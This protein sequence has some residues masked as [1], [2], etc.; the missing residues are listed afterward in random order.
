VERL[1]VKP[2]MDGYEQRPALYYWPMEWG[3][4]KRQAQGSPRSS[5]TATAY[6]IIPCLVSVV[7]G[8]LLLN[9]GTHSANSANVN[10]NLIG[11]I[12]GVALISA[13]LLVLL[14]FLVLSVIATAYWLAARRRRRSEPLH[15]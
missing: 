3:A 14:L 8:G 11:T 7:L 2:T 13:G 4:W 1:A 12:C 5:L 10:P 9:T 6:V 15:P